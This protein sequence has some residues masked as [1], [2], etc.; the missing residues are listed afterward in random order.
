MRDLDCKEKRR[1]RERDRERERAR[2]RDIC[3]RPVA[4]AANI[5]IITGEIDGARASVCRGDL[6]Y[7]LSLGAE[8][9]DW[10]RGI[11]GKGRRK[12]EERRKRGRK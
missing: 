11:T 2:A 9:D 8:I 3:S 5:I 6:S 1:E 10:R 7:W 4:A 12:R